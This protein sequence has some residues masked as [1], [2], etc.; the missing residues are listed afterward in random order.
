MP[1]DNEIID[2]KLIIEV[3]GC[4]HYQVTGFA[5]M[6]SEKYNTTPEQELEYLQWKDNY[7]KQYALDNGYYYLEIPYWTEKD[8]SYK[9]L[10][11]N[12]INEIMKEVV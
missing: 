11:D 7:K 9:A 3:H 8:D 1:Y 4:Q 12:K 10:I 6:S 2:M 5:K